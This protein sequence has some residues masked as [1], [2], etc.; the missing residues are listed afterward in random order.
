M[1]DNIDTPADITSLAGDF[2]GD[3]VIDFADASILLANGNYAST[4]AGAQNILCDI[5]A[6]EMVTVSDLSIVLANMAG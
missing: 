2:N 4:A 3:N 5:D 1:D 6:D